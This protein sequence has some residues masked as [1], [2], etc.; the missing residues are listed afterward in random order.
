MGLGHEADRSRY[1]KSRPGRLFWAD[2]PE[3]ERLE[4]RALLTLTFTDFPLPLVEVV[5]PQG[6]TAGADGNLWFTENRANRIGR[7][8]PAGALTEFPL[9]AD[10]TSPG[11]IAAGPDGNLWVG[12]SQSLGDS[13]QE[14]VIV[15]ITPGGA[16]TVFALPMAT[17]NSV[18]DIT[19]GPD[20]ALWFA[21]NSGKVGR[22]T[23]AGVVSEVDLPDV[24][25]PSTAPPG[26]A[27]SPVTPEAITTGP[28]GNLWFTTDVGQVDR[29][30]TSG[31]VAGFPVDGLSGGPSR[32]ART[33]PSG[34]R[35]SMGRSAA[36][37]HRAW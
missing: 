8:T 35:G 9:P 29:M 19:V 34:S 24:P 26:T 18:S 20:G 25:P 16:E 27:A 21:G 5:E 11:P 3:P 1:R 36:S 31:A 32:R 15:R 23:T 10:V 4:E 7:E 2:A 13:Q 12:A 22:I 6:I 33:G 28:D 14:A 17:F 37:P 30:S